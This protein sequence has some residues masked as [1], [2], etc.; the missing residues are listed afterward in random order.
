ME[1]YVCIHGH[2]YQPPRENPWLEELELQDSAYPYHDWNARITHECYRP[3]AAS[4]ILGPDR[5]IKDV[6]NNYS[7]ISFDVGPT[8]MSWLQRHQ[9]DVYQA[10]LQA[11]TESQTLFS[12]HGAGMAQAYNHMIMPLANE[13][14]KRTQVLWGI[15]DFTARFERPPEGMWLPETAVDSPTLEVLAE[16]GIL[17]TVLAPQQAKS[18]RAPGAT[19]WQPLEDDSIDTT[20]AYHCPLPSGRS[21][22]LFFYQGNLAQNVAS[23]RS[24]ESGERLAQELLELGQDQDGHPC[25]AHIATDGETY[26]HHFRHTD[27]A[28][29][30]CLQRIESQGQ[31]QVTVY[32]EYLEKYPPT[33]AVEIHENSAWSCSHGVGRWRSNCGCHHGQ[34]PS[35]Q[36]AYR[37]ILREALDWLRDELGPIYEQ[38]VKQY[39]DDPWALRNAY[40]QVVNDRRRANVEEFLTAATCKTLAPTDKTQVLKLLEMQRHAMLMYTSCAWFFDDISGLEA[41]QIL[42]YASRAM[43]LGKETSGRDL[44]PDFV[45]ML[46]Q[47][48]CNVQAYAH[49]KDVYQQRVKPCSVDLNRVGAHLALSTLFDPVQ[50]KSQVYCYATKIES[51]DRH[52]AGPQR[53]AT[54]RAMITSDIVW[55]SQRFDFAG[56]F[57]GD[58]KLTG[59][60]DT[61]LE[62]PVF[63]SMQSKLKGAFERS[64][65]AE[66]LQVMNEVFQENIYSV[67]HVFK[68]EQRHLLDHLMQDTWKGIGASFRQI[69]EQN[70]EI[71][72][73]MRKAHIPLPQAL[74]APAA[75][76]VNQELRRIIQTDS[77]DG[78]RLQDLL[79]ESTRLGIHLDHDGLRYEA[80]HK[81]VECLEQLERKPD[82]LRLLQAAESTLRALRDL[83]DQL[84]LHRAQTILFGLSKTLFQS[85][86]VQADT[87]DGPAAQQRELFGSLAQHLDVVIESFGD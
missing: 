79:D 38:Q 25:L 78:M 39:C 24:L 47:A 1:K 53:L 84:A 36:Q 34:F 30:Y 44:E 23:G 64:D 87:E 9:R 46:E 18:V 5:T 75:F 66:M 19:E 6:V 82:S 22:S 58:C 20:Q 72:Q 29:A 55:E 12:G 21:I 31:A 69:Y 77:I 61:R 35:G 81:V 48:P 62:D 54:G 33:Q 40:I 86:Q 7:K 10:V 37:K 16:A 27:M 85:K 11:D 17:F 49:G 63:T 26:G 83:S 15:A 32:G 28:L 43:Q 56:V 45:Q 41:V 71:M 80:G 59:A 8:L 76:T 52:E 51:Y 57:L 60:V 68:D 65:S 2:F 13:R 73:F 50:E 3:N 74:A 67:W 70:L 14:D 4:R 42:Q